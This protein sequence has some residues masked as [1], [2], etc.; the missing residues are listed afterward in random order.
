[1]VIRCLPNDVE[2]Y[3][4][5]MGTATRRARLGAEVPREGVAK[6]VTGDFPRRAPDSEATFS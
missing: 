3:A 1:M 4:G 6:S 2:P 5:E